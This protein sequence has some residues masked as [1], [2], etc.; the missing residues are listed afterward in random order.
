M[1]PAGP[2][3]RDGPR[4]GHEGGG[5]PSVAGIP[6]PRHDTSPM[7]VQIAWRIAAISSTGQTGPLDGLEVD[8]R[9]SDRHCKRL[10]FRRPHP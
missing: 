8:A 9:R 7:T 3:S 1:P 5:S 4:A 10:Q 6:S 2:R